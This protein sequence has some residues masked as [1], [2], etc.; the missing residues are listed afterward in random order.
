MTTDEIINLKIPCF[1]CAYGHSCKYY[2][3]TLWDDWMFQHPEDGCPALKYPYESIY[4][5][6]L[7]Q[8]EEAKKQ[9]RFS[10]ASE[11]GITRRKNNG[12]RR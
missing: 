6:A 4:I 11:W 3:N 1:S 10:P 9:K 7:K 2:S 8:A 5:S 12:N